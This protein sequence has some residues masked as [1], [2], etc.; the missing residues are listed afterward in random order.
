LKTVSHPAAIGVEFNFNTIPGSA[1]EYFRRKY[2]SE[3]IIGIS[4]NAT[5]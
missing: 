2:S 1:E 3:Y 5:E 4:L